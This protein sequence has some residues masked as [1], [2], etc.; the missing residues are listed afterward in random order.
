VIPCHHPLTVVSAIL[1][2]KSRTYL[3]QSSASAAR[4]SFSPKEVNLE[5]IEEI[6]R[7][8][9]SLYNEFGFIYISSLM[10]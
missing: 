6:Q 10:V 2:Q 9:S 5:Y 1:A 4:R 8:P 3:K 7:F